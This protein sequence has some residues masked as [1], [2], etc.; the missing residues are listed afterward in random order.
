MYVNLVQNQRAM[1]LRGHG[2]P[3]R[4]TIEYVAKFFHTIYYL[5]FLQLNKSQ[6]HTV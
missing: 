5:I 3:A 4:V 6:I 2:L 1:P